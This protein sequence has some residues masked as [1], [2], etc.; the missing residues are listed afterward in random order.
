ME[1]YKIRVTTAPAK[2]PTEETLSLTC[3]HAAIRYGQHRTAPGD[4]LEVFRG[5]ECIFISEDLG[6]RRLSFPSAAV[7]R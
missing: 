7:S 2:Q 6:P 4:K 1:T 3:D 5:K